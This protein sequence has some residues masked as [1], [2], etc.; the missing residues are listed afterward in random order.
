MRVPK[1][2]EQLRPNRLYS[3][4][5]ATPGESNH[6]YY[7]FWSYTPSIHAE[8]ELQTER[9]YC[10]PQSNFPPVPYSTWLP[11]HNRAI[12]IGTVAPQYRLP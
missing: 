9:D 2:L 3:Q 12:Y 8:Y 7:W 1:T 10:F 5:D 4:Q 6:C 11:P